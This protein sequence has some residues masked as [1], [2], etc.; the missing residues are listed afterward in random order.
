MDT[1]VREVA[2]QFD[3]AVELSRTAREPRDHDRVLDLLHEAAYRPIAAFDVATGHAGD[4]DAVRRLLACELLGVL[5]ESHADLQPRVV[6]AVLAA[7]PAEADEAI[8]TAMARA[9]GAC[10]DPR[11]LP[12]LLHLADHRS[13]GVRRA[14]AAALPWVM[15]DE[16]PDGGV[17]A[18][19][20]LS[21][22]EDPEVR[23][24][25][26]FGLGWM[27]PVDSPEI[28]AVLVA[29]IDDP[30]PDAREEGIRGLA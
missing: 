12:A 3:L 24:W 6:A 1:A 14:V 8:T 20:R 25:A 10:A 16:V 18:L 22:D 21:A 27:L 15:F 5:A 28:R 11:G 9:L 13:A 19:L 2:A 30:Y 23:N 7:Y 17:A 26:T 29:R 4:A